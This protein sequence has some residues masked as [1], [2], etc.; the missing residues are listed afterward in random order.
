MKSGSLTHTFNNLVASLQESNQAKD[1]VEI[2]TKQRLEELHL[3][4]EKFFKAFH[5]SP[6][7]MV[8]QN[9]EDRT[10]LDVNA[11]FSQITGYDREEA[12]GHTPGEVNIYPTDEDAERVAEAVR[13]ITRSSE[14]F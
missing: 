11:A 5:S 3:S 2:R 13:R 8:L 1:A 10:Y 4:E 6:V 14:K 7:V 12:V 9:R